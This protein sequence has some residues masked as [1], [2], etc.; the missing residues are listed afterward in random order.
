MKSTRIRILTIGAVAVLAVT[1][2][3]AQGPHGFGGPGDGFYHMLKQLDL[4]NA[5]HEQVKAIWAKENPAIEPL[6]QQMRQNRKAM[7]ALE[8]SGPFDEAKTRALATQNVQTM[9]ELQVEHARAKS[10]IMQILT[11]EQKAKLAAMEANR[12]AGMGK[13]GPPPPED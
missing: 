8:A 13:H 1:A 3:L 10:E 11:A 2:A 9:I 4:T 5:Q 12:E 7:K 6:V